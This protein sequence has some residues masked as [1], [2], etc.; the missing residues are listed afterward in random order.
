MGKK[1]NENFYL[2]YILNGTVLDSWKEHNRQKQD[3]YLDA[4]KKQQV[5]YPPPKKKKITIF[6]TFQS[7][8]SNKKMRFPR[9]KSFLGMIISLATS[10]NNTCWSNV[11][12]FKK[13]GSTKENA[14]K[15][16]NTL[17]SNQ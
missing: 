11:T 8:E 5:N 1:I 12:A 3:M 14:A 7:Y 9:K 2:K 13:G 6:I 4:T 15:D 17:Q 10:S 16:T